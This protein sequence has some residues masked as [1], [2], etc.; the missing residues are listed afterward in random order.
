MKDRDAI[1][2]GLYQEYRY[3]LSRVSDERINP[4]SAQ[5]LLWIMLN[6]STADAQYDDPTIRRCVSF[7]RHWGFGAMRVVNLYAYRSTEPKVLKKS[8]A[9]W[10]ENVARGNLGAFNPIGPSNDNYIADMGR[11]SGEVCLAWG[12]HAE[13]E[14]VTAVMKVL[15]TVQTSDRIFFLNLTKSGQPVHPLYQALATPRRYINIGEELP[16]EAWAKVTNG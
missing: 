5:R 1:L 6:P 13:P 12:S 11:W 4:L 3:V 15:D 16:S 9:D 10:R 2:G 14:R 7:S 8:L